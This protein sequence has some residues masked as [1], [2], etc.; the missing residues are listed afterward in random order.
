MQTFENWVWIS[1][2]LHRECKS[3]VDPNLEAKI[4]GVNS[5]SSPKLHDFEIICQVGG[6]HS[7]P[8]LHTGL[9]FVLK[10]M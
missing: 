5:V 9:E 1:C 4:R 7:H 6:A 3:L 2:I 10:A 8:P